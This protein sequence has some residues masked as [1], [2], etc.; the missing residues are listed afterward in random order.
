MLLE[1][2]KSGLNNL[3][4]ECGIYINIPCKYFTEDSVN[5]QYNVTLYSQKSV[6]ENKQNASPRGE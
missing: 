2:Y 4:N 1:G 3:V 5:L 6:S